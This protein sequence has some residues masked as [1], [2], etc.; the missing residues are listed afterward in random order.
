LSILPG[1]GSAQAVGPVASVLGLAQL[2]FQAVDATP[3][4][5]QFSL[6]GE[7]QVLQ[8]LVPIALE[9]AFGLLLHLRCLAANGLEHIVHKGRSMV[10]VEPAALH[11]L[12][13]DV[14]EPVGHQG[15]GAE[16]PQ[17]KHL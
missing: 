17:E 3:Q 8:E 14:A 16:T 10:G 1:L 13:G 2:A 7:A 15:G 6:T 11:P 12:L 4:F 5:I 9:L